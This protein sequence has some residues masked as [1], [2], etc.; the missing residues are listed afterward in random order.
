M[1]L[2]RNLKMNKDSNWFKVRK[3]YDFHLLS[4]IS[5]LNTKENKLSGYI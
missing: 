3:S 1:K 5:L 4:K 2:K